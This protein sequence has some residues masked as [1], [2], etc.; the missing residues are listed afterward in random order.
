MLIEL[1]IGF[2]HRVIT[3]DAALTKFTIIDWIDWKIRVKL[4][5]I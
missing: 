1:R 4:E 5:G 3:L 2:L